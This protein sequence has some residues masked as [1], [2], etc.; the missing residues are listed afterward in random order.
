MLY[1]L[2]FYSKQFLRRPLT[3]NLETLPHD[4][5]LAA[6]ENLL[7]RLPSFALPTKMGFQIP[8]CYRLGCHCHEGLYAALC[9]SHSKPAG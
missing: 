3:D 2:Y 6:V 8:L 7:C 4:V 5:A 1:F 9:A